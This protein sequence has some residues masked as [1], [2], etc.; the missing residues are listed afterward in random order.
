MKLNLII[1]ANLRVKIKGSTAHFLYSIIQ[2]YVLPQNNSNGK[3]LAEINLNDG[4]LTMDLQSDLK[5]LFS[6]IDKDF[7]YL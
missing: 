1:I 2:G 5:T 6:A 3:L 4:N 7:Q